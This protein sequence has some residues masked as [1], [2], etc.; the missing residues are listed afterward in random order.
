MGGGAGESFSRRLRL[1]RA[2]EY[3][4][5]FK[6]N[7]RRSDSCMTILVGRCQGECPRLGFAIARKQVPKAVQRNALKR[8]F[9][10][11]FRRNRTRL[12][13]RDMVIM[14]KR[15]ILALDRERIRTRLDQHWNSI[16]ES[17]DK[18]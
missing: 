7:T 4:Q 9:R 5:V 13:S 15:D 10:E 3:R 12:P 11:S 16:I 8:L 6:D 18:S 1:T 17:C 2:D 14:V